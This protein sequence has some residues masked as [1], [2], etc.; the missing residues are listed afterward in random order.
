[1]EVERV[2]K[3]VDG[4]ILVNRCIQR[5][6]P[7]TKFSNKKA[8]ELNLPFIVCINKIDRPER[9]EDVMDEVLELLLRTELSDDEQLDSP[10]VYASAK[11]WYCD[12]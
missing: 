7:Q 5:I 8:L 9:Q 6:I 12:A 11:I 4:V 3:M 10:F 2:L 1:M